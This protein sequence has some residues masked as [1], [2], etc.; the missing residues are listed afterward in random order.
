MTAHIT[1]RISDGARTSD[2]LILRSWP[3]ALYYMQRVSV[4]LGSLVFLSH[5]PKVESY[6]PDY[7]STLEIP[8]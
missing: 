3:L 7:F 2:R 6:C 5:F 4:E 8:C 1:Y